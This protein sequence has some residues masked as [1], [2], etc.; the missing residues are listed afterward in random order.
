MGKI[1]LF[2]PVFLFLAAMLGW[3]DGVDKWDMSARFE[4]VG[5][6][7]TV[8]LRTPTRALRAAAAKAKGDDPEEGEIIA[9]PPPVLAAKPA[10]G[11]KKKKK[12]GGASSE[13]PKPRPADSGGSA[14]TA[15]PPTPPESSEARSVPFSPVIPTGRTP[16][17]ARTR[18]S[19]SA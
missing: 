4:L 15:A 12:S 10:G 7:L 16:V 3:L 6:A 14:V 8:S 18:A 1:G 9:S 11:K 5:E 2:W 17:A 19:T 13:I